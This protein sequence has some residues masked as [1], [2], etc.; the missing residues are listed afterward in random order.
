MMYSLNDPG[1][2][3]IHTKN[4]IIEMQLKILLLRYQICRLTWFIMTVLLEILM[5]S[6]MSVNFENKFQYKLL[7]LS[8]FV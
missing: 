2:T 5:N 1:E 3:D 7:F 6:K 4:I 8:L